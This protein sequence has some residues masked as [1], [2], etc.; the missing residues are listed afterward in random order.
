M[1]SS[2]AMAAAPTD[3]SGPLISVSDNVLPAEEQQAVFE[4]LKGPGW[5]FGGF[6]DKE[7]ARYFYKH[8]A[9]YHADPNAEAGPARFEQELLAASPL[10]AG[11][12][13]RLRSGLLKGHALSR[14]YA[15]GMPNGTDGSLH[16]DSNIDS[17][18]TTIYY[19]HLSWHPNFAGETV[20][21]D[22]SGSDIVASVYPR[23]NRIVMFSG[24]IPHVARATSRKGPDLRITLMFK[25]MPLADAAA[26]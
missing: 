13:E 20:F 3:T 21:F 15:N 25:T 22:K 26:R 23:P 4:F 24:T 11:V 17:H 1:A 12:W 14:C 16:L 10:I 2:A 7:G 6:S 18:L 5:A 19:P 8:F 9:G